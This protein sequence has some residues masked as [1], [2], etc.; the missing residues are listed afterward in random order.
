M[1]SLHAQDEFFFLLPHES[2]EASALSVS[3]P[4]LAPRPSL[5]LLLL[6][7]SSSF[8]LL[9]SPLSTPYSFHPGGVMPPTHNGSY[10]AAGKPIEVPPC[11]LPQGRAQLPKEMLQPSIRQ[12]FS[13]ADVFITGGTG[14]VGSV[15]IEQL[16]RLVPDVGTIFMLVRPKAGASGEQRIDNLLNKAA[17]FDSLRVGAKPGDGEL[18]VFN[19]GGVRA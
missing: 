9:S 16:L 6:L 17:L 8:F 2:S 10:K 3:S 1:P 12:A 15:M 7:T 18:G 4:S 11:A 5:L 14:F 13:G 19:F